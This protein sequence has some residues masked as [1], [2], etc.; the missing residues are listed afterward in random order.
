MHSFLGVF[1]YISAKKS[2]DTIDVSRW[3]KNRKYIYIYRSRDSL[4]EFN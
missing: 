3:L 1:L 4:V 2:K